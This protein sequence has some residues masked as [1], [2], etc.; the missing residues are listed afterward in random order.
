MSSVYLASDAATM[1]KQ[2]AVKILNTSHADEIKRE[3]FNRETT[4]LRRLTHP[5]IVRMLDSN[6]SESENSFY[7]VLDYIPYSLDSYLRGELG[8]RFSNLEPYPLMRQLVEALAYAHAEGVVHRDVKP[9]NILFDEN[10]RPMLTDFGISKL[11]THLTIGDTLA[12]F[13]SGGYASPEQ[14]AGKIATVASDVYSLGAVFFHLLSGQEPPAEGPSPSMVDEF[15]DR[16]PRPLRNMLKRMLAHNPADRISSG[17]ELLRVIDVTRRFET[18]PNYFLILTRNAIHDIVS[19]GYSPSE[20]F[21]DISNVLLEDLGGMDLE[22]VHIHRDNRNKDDFIILGGELRLICT[23]NEEQDAFLIKAVQ[24]PYMP[25]LDAEKGRSMTHR[26]MWT[27]VSRT[28]R[29]EEPSDSLKSAGEQLTNLLSTLDTYQKVGSVVQERRASR[30]EF[31]ERW[32]AALSQSRNRIEKEASAI[33]Y[34]SVV[35]ESNYLRFTLTE[36]PSDD[37]DWKEDTPLAVRRPDESHSIPVGNLVD[38]RGRTVEVAKDVGRFIRRNQ[39]IPR[40]G[41]LML[42]VLEASTSISRQQFAV[43]SFLYDRMS[44]P[45]LARAIIDPSTATRTPAPDL[46]FFQEW[47]VGRQKRCSQARSFQQRDF[48]NP[49]PARHRKNVCHCR[50]R[51][52]VTSPESGRTHLAHFSIEHRRGPRTGTDSRCI[53]ECGRLPTVNGQVGARRENRLWRRELDSDRTRSVVEAGSP[54]SMQSGTRCSKK[55][56]TQCST[57]YQGFWCRN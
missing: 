48:P 19:T 15:I 33:S 47:F 14:R 6:W 32:N 23:P 38:I 50:N 54:E 55:S 29:N 4:A 45:V 7:I 39:A 27:P 8:G 5:N 1:D 51:V 30:R 34:S 43:N 10:L 9:S 21:Q 25:N 36:S 2:V 11:M 44:N 3:L 41:Q 26:A 57:G 13:W 56:R 52:A 22:E 49:R 46:E 40:R 17:V 53:R 20:D 24:T 31:I 42:N 28:F 35:D 18:V 12:G 16:Q 37:L